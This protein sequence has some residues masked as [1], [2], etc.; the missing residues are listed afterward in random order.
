MSQTLTVEAPTKEARCILRDTEAYNQFIENLAYARQRLQDVCN[1]LEKIGIVP[2]DF[3]ELLDN[4]KTPEE[5][6]RR[7]LMEKA[8]VWEGFKA[9]LEPLIPGLEPL[10]EAVINLFRTFAIKK[11]NGAAFFE[12]NGSE[13]VIQSKRAEQYRANFEVWLSGKELERFEA[14]ESFATQANEYRQKTGFNLTVEGLAY[15][16]RTNQLQPDMR[17]FYDPEKLGK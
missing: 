4:L 5:Y 3:E 7:K 14:L 16:Y 11:L 8:P 6:V 15:N 2:A 9:N 17:L 12:L 1:E 13:V 10:R